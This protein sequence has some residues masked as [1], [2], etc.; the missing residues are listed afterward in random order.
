MAIC[1]GATRTSMLQLH[2]DKNVLFP[3]LGKIYD[4]TISSFGIQEPIHVAKCIIKTI[5]KADNG[6]IVLIDEGISKLVVFPEIQY[7]D[8]E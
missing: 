8:F 7:N 5:E 2:S 1:P 4:S 6:S 3:F